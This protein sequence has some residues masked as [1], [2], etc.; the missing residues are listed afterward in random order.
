MEDKTNK[1]NKGQVLLSLEFLFKLINKN[2]DRCYGL[3]NTCD[4]PLVQ[5][6]LAMKQGD[7]QQGQDQF[8]LSALSVFNLSFGSSSLE[9]RSLD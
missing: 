5:N 6:S 3:T 8:I 4:S 9:T 2:A 7:N 1:T